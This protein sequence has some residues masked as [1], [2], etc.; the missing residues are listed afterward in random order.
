MNDVSLGISFIF[1]VQ[2]IC[3]MDHP[4]KS[5]T[6]HRKNSLLS[7]EGFLDIVASLR[8]VRVLSSSLVFAW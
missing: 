1:Y 5:A 8:C 6:Q 4:K 2:V 7:N 3:T